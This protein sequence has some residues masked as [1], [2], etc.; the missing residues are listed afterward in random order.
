MT[1][2]FVRSEAELDEAMRL[3]RAGH[4]DNDIARQLGIPRRTISDWRRGKNLRRP[5]IMRSVQR[6]PHWDRGLLKASAHAICL[7]AGPLSGGWLHQ[8]RSAWRLAPPNNSR[9]VVSGNHPGVR[10]RTGG[11]IP[12]KASASRRPPQEPLRRRFHV[13]TALAFPDSPAWRRTKASPPHRLGAVAER[14]SL[15][16]ARAFP[17]GIDSQRRHSDR[18]NGAQGHLRQ[19]SPS[20]CIQQ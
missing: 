19:T 4:P 5:P 11:S 1:A 18:G 9:F 15:A 12:R 20:L 8:R 3:A 2:G 14:D 7:S 10:R 17:P 13:V 6:S 16:P